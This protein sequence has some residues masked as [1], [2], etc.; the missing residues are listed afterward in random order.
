MILA[1]LLFS[2]MT[3]ASLQLPPKEYQV[4]V[5]IPTGSIEKW[6]YNSISNTIERDIKNN[7]FRS[8]NYLGYPFNYGIVL[9]SYNKGDSDPLDA[10][11]IA[12]NLV[13]GDTIFAKPLAVIQTKDQQQ[14]D[15]KLIFVHTSSP[16][17]KVNSLQELETLFP[18][19]IDI[20]CIF[21]EN[22]KKHS[23]VM[24]VKNELH[25]K[26]IIEQSLKNISN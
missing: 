2:I 25:A 15:N 22:Y 6:E 12:Q 11:I 20:A 18:G 26:K 24:G 14:Q 8:I 4:M 23:S 5:E 13:M 19:V 17:Y 16:L 7:Q 3:F 10:I 9:N 21:F 1:P